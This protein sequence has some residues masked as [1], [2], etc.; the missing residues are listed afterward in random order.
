[1]HFFGRDGKGK[2]SYDKF[3]AFLTKLQRAVLLLEF[4]SHTVDVNDTISA[5]ACEAS[6]CAMLFSVLAN[7]RRHGLGTLRTLTGLC[8][9]AGRLRRPSTT[10]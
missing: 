9:V 2:C 5:Q 8:A 4:Y 1:V 10:G 7:H 3:S 6:F